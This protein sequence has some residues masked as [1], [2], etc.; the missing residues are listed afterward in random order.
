M[1][2]ALVLKK[3]KQ[4]SEILQISVL[5]AAFEEI[6]RGGLAAGAGFILAVQQPALSLPGVCGV[7]RSAGDLWMTSGSTGSAGGAGVLQRQGHREPYLC[8][9]ASRSD[10]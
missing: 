4:V 2:L 1:A 6:D 8:P 3:E 7:A 10:F 5:I 9:A